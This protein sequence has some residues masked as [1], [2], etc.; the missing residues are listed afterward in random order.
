MI[1]MII[2]MITKNNRQADV[3]VYTQHMF[4]CSIVNKSGYVYFVYTHKHIL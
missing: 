4:S 3:S 1:I 2:A